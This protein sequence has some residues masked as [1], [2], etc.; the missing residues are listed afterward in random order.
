MGSPKTEFFLTRIKKQY[1]KKN[2]NMSVSFS[3]FGP[4]LNW[5]KT[6]EI[7]II[8]GFF[9]KIKRLFP[10]TQVFGNVLAFSTC[11]TQKLTSIDQNSMIFFWNSMMFYRNSSFF[12]KLNFSANSHDLLAVTTYVEKKI[13]ICMMWTNL[14]HDNC[15]IEH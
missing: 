12:S 1:C 5:Q 4:R 6:Q 7:T 9:P 15:K 11:S 2:T 8:P 10:K 14:I 13:W 3:S